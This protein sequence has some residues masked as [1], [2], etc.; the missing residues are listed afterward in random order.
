MFK[1]RYRDDNILIA[2]PNE[3]NLTGITPETLT[4]PAVE[5]NEEEEHIS[6]Y[7]EKSELL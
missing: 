1:P 5:V 7:N 2:I 6:V 3:E 4:S